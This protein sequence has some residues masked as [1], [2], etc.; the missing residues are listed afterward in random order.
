M[1]SAL[2]AFAYG[3][4]A[5]EKDVRKTKDDNDDAQVVDSDNDDEALQETQAARL[6]QSLVDVAQMNNSKPAKP[7]G[8]LADFALQQK[9]QSQQPASQ[10]PAALSLLQVAQQ[11]NQEAQVKNRQQLASIAAQLSQEDAETTKQRSEKIQNALQATSEEVR[12]QVQAKQRQAIEQAVQQAIIEEQ[13]YQQDDEFESEDDPAVQQAANLLIAKANAAAANQNNDNQ[14]PSNEKNSTKP[15][16]LALSVD[17]HVLKQR[18]NQYGLQSKSTSKAKTMKDKLSSF[19]FHQLSITQRRLFLA[20]L[21]GDDAGAA[22]K[23][24]KTNKYNMVRC[25]GCCC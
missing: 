21:V 7:V 2:A 4:G 20:T 8:S 3:L 19:Q 9:Q 23:K 12:A 18:Q 10:Q 22:M 11:E 5:K 17:R 25:Y 15:T 24:D 6:P 13:Q 1:A 16:A 14:H